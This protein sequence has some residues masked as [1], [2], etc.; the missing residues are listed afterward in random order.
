ME[1]TRLGLALCG[2]FCTFAKVMD[3]AR[4]LSEKYDVIP[5]MSENSAT[6]DTRFGKAELFRERLEDYSGHDIIDSIVAAEPIGPKKLLDVLVIAPC[7][8]NTI[9]KLANGIADTAVT[10][11]VKAHLRN[12]RPVVIAISTNDGLSTNAENIGRLMAR[13][14]IYLVPFRQDNPTGKPCSLVADF[15]KIDAA[16]QAALQ[17]KQIQ[18]LLI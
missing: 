13:K 8:G 9:G 7:T 14:H 12:E 5:I 6:T 15:N 3:I 11:A 16:V 4:E 18:P 2:S 10:L 1:K 17:E